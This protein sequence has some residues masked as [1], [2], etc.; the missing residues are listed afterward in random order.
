MN[1]CIVAVVANHYFL[2][3]SRAIAPS[4]NGSQ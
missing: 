1:Y 2:P 3:S 4:I